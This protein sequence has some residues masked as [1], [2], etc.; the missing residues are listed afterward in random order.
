MTSN[1]KHMMTVRHEDDGI[2]RGWVEDVPDQ[3]HIKG[4]PD[5]TKMGP[6]ERAQAT[7]TWFNE[8]LQSHE[9]RRKLLSVGMVTT[10]TEEIWS[11]S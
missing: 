4:S 8:T 7:I 1:V 10:T 5:I 2:D 3:L 9:P 6:V 11:T